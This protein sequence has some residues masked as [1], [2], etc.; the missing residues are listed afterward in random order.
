MPTIDVPGPAGRCRARGCGSLLWL[1]LSLPWLCE[2]SSLSSP[3][4]GCLKPPKS[5]CQIF[6]KAV[7]TSVPQDRS[8]IP[9]PTPWLGS[10]STSELS[11]RPSRAPCLLFPG[12]GTVLLACPPRVLWK[13]WAAVMSVKCIT[14]YLDPFFLTHGKNSWESLIRWWL[15][16]ALPPQAPGLW[17]QSAPLLWASMTSP[18]APHDPR[19]LRHLYRSAAFNLH[20]HFALHAGQL[21]WRSLNRTA[22]DLVCVLQQ[23]PWSALWDLNSLYEITEG[24]RAAEIKDLSSAGK[25]GDRRNQ[26][27]FVIGYL[28]MVLAANAA[29]VL[30]TFSCMK[31]SVGTEAGVWDMR[32]FNGHMIPLLR[33]IDVMLHQQCS[34]LHI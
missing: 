5:S 12:K 20:L 14:V 21:L 7:R 9:H 30:R 1:R 26:A 34:L 17:H 13:F 29:C 31:C 27:C 18:P 32:W 23:S 6:C 28:A 22:N 10:C 19:V 2:C 15:P 4:Q 16:L 24:R 8:S 11:C 3:S 33:Q 25:D